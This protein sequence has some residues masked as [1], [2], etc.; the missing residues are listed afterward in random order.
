MG[1]PCVYHCA[2]PG[3][4]NL[5]LGGLETSGQRLYCLHW[6]RTPLDVFF[7]FCDDFLLFEI[8]FGFGVIVNQPSLHNEGVSRGRVRGCGC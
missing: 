1:A 8:L 3:A 2:C 7:G 5:F 4:E 6:H